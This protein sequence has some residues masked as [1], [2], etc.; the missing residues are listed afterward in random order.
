VQF[1]SARF[2]GDPVLQAI[3]DDPDTGT[4]KLQSGSDPAAVTKVQQAF[5]DLNWL[6]RLDILDAS[7]FPLPESQFVV[8]T[9]GPITTNVVTRYKRQFDIHFPPSSPTGII[10]GFVGPRTLRLLDAQVA[11]IDTAA[12]AIETKANDLIAAGTNVTFS[13]GSNAEPDTLPIPGTNGAKRVCDDIG[14]ELGIIY[15]KAGIGAVELHGGIIF[16]YLE[17]GG[18]GG[19]LGF[20]TSD[21]GPDGAGGLQADFEHGSIGFDPSSGATTVNVPAPGLTVVF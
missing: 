9:Y 1:A 2:D 3:L 15:F 7:G 8:G 6:R 19:P 11:L 10:D 20:P 21:V 12:D 13:A 14:G 18:P 4:Q 17:N 5:F 16:A